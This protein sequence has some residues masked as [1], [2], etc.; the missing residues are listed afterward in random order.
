MRL[1]HTVLGIRKAEEHLK[2]A[3][4]REKDWCWKELTE[5]LD[6]D[7]WGQ[8]LPRSSKDVRGWS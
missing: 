3:F 8:C 2:K 7:I 1:K 4:F 6:D 5:E